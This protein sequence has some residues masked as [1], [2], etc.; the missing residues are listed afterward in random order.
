MILLLSAGNCADTTTD[1]KTPDAGSETNTDQTSEDN[2]PNDP[3]D[4][5]DD[6]TGEDTND[7]TAEDTGEDTNDDT[8][9]ASPDD[10]VN[11]PPDA[12]MEGGTETKGFTF[13]VNSKKTWSASGF[14]MEKDHEYTITA[15]IDNKWLDASV[16]A[17]LDGWLNEADP[18]IPVFAPLRRIVDDAIGFYQFAACIDKK[19]N[20]CFAVGNETTITPRISGEP[21]FFVNDVPGF[22]NNN[23]GTA[24][25]TIK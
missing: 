15:T 21:F 5:T 8:L 17:D 19:E 16:P 18:R 4:D 9:D 6:D 2:S 3:N 11:H 12:S 24:T 13:V 25:V 20:H 10:P 7:D 1:S 23:V 14:N 22:E